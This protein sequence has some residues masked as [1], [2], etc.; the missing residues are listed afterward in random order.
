MVHILS[1]Y[2]YANA[3]TAAAQSAEYEYRAYC[4]RS[5]FCYYI[6]VYLPETEHS[7]WF[8]AICTSGQCINKEP[9]TQKQ[10]EHANKSQ[11][12][13]DRHIFYADPRIAAY[14]LTVCND[15]RNK[16]KDCTHTI[17]R[18][19]KLF[20]LCLRCIYKEIANL[21]SCKLTAQYEKCC[22]LYRYKS[23][24]CQYDCLQ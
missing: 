2:T 15:Q 4:K 12:Y 10:Q 20:L 16:T 1:G 6:F 19:R 8:C 11:C 5:R 13:G 3:R 23:N 21:L 22:K 7:K 14:S 18:S 17:H 9:E 24:S